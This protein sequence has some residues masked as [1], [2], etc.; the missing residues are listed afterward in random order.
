MR[1]VCIARIAH[2]IN[3][4]ETHYKKSIHYRV[5]RIA[6]AINSVETHLSVLDM[7]NVLARIAHA[8][9]SVE[10]NYELLT[11]ALN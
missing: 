5:A 3:S 2:A 11:L 6:H 7:I 8:I 1:F 10:T 4:V 9:N